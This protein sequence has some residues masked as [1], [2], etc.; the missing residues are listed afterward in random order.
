MLFVVTVVAPIIAF[1]WR[2][3]ESSG[4]I[5]VTVN[6]R[7]VNFDGQQPI[8]VENRVLVPVRGVFEHVGFVST[9]DASARMAQLARHDRYV[10]IHA[11]SPEFRVNNDIFVPDVPPRFTNDRMMLPLRAVAEALGGT[12]EWDSN[13][14]VARITLAAPAPAPT[15]A[16]FVIPERELT[17]YELNQWIREYHSNGGIHAFELEVLALVNEIRAGHGLA[18]LDLSPTLMIASRFKAQSTIDIGYFSHTSPV[19]G[20]FAN[21]SRQ[22]FNYPIAAMAE[23]IA[24]GQRTPEAVVAAWMDSQGHRNNILNPIYT[25]MGV[26]FHNYRW[27]QKFGSANTAS[28]PAPTGQ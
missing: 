27:V 1:A 28:I 17:Q 21:I 25:E 6:G 23:N 3:G 20:H 16:P 5:T 9:W 2:A 11:G 10:V 22:L 24:R 18:T 19:Y 4:H 7:Q 13:S 14:R 8:M 12:A 15:P 26:G